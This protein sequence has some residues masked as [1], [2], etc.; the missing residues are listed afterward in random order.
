[1]TRG[2]GDRL[3]HTLSKLLAANPPDLARRLLAR[4]KVYVKDLTGRIARPGLWFRFAVRRPD[5][6][7]RLVR[8]LADVH[9]GDDE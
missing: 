5:D 3:I 6:N 2:N 9:G 7:A 4:H 1:M 8:I